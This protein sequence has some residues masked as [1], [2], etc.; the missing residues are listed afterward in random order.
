LTNTHRKPGWK[1]SNEAGALLSNQANLPYEGRAYDGIMLNTYKAL[2]YLQ[3]G[4]PTRP[5]WSS[6][7][8]TS[9]KQDA[10]RTING[11]SKKSRK[12]P[13]RAKDKA[14]MYKAERD[15]QFKAQNAGRLH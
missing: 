7:A 10:S 5:A 14:T 3:L 15:P 6:S 8:P 12:K 2:N 11:A 13:P 9:A 1:I 4:E